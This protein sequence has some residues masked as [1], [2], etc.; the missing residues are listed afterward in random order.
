MNAVLISYCLSDFLKQFN[1]VMSLNSN[2]LML[3]L[4]TQ[5]DQRT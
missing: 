3:G 1:D 2:G 4:R 5:T